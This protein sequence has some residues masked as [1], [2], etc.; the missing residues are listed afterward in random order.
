MRIIGYSER[1]A[2]NALFYGMALDKEQGEESMKTFLK[3]AKIKGNF[4]DFELYNEFSLSDFG[5]PDLMIIA[6]NEDS[7]YVVFFYRGEGQL[8]QKLL[9]SKA[10]NTAQ[11][12]YE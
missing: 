10:R 7:E 9:P 3:L 12:L 6:K 2:M 4:T 5:D 8:L 1:G 11:E